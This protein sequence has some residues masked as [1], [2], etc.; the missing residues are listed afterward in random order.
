M[1]LGGV[2]V[3]DLLGLDPELPS[4]P[5]L[6]LPVP[7]I[8]K[9]P[10]GN[11]QGKGGWWMDSA[12]L[13]GKIQK[14]KIFLLRKMQN[15]WIPPKMWFIGQYFRFIPDKEGNFQVWPW[16]ATI[17]MILS[18]LPSLKSFSSSSSF[19]W[20]WVRSSQSSTSFETKMWDHQA[21]S[22][23]N[24]DEVIFVVCKDWCKT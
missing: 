8:G 13:H 3:Y 7:S 14:G 15:V 24:H 4:S 5:S 2:V 17:T 1:K 10:R 23:Q 22:G 16:W 9:R 11:H 18:L 21:N 19:F 12:I 20:V 6:C